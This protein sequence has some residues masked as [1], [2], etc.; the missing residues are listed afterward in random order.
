M[1]LSR[2]NGPVTVTAKELESASAFRQRAIDD[3]KSLE[4]LRNA[5]IISA[6]DYHG[7]VLFS[8]DA[9]CDVFD[10]LFAPNIEADRPRDGHDRP[11]HR[12]LLVE[13]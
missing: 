11:H 8:G 13:P 10:H 3:L 6:D 12:G 9:M 2:D 5:P 4:E 7:P 1:R